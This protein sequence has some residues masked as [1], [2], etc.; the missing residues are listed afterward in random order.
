[1]AT[2]KQQ[3]QQQKKVDGNQQS[4]QGRTLPTIWKAVIYFCLLWNW[5]I[6]WLSQTGAIQMGSGFA[7]WLADF[8]AFAGFFA[9]VAL[10]AAFKYIE[11]D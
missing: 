5:I 8:S 2:S 4:R 7:E 11:D 1:M 10:F 9:V 3:N 6:G